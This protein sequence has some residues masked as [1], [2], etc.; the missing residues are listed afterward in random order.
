MRTNSVALLQ[1]FV[2]EVWLQNTQDRAGG[3]RTVARFGLE[4]DTFGLG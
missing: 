3:D 4:E 2:E 1:V